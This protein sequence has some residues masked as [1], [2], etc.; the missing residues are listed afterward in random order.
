M[1]NHT[2]TE[3]AKGVMA[4]TP[5]SPFL[6]NY[7]LKDM[8]VFFAKRDCIYM[9]YADDILILADSKEKLEELRNDLISIISSK[10]LEMNPEKE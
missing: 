4:G 9:R 2:I 7:Y 3:E 8:D 5:V 10:G 1:F 6:A